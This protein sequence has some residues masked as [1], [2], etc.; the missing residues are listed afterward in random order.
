MKKLIDIKQHSDSIF[1]CHVFLMHYFE[2]K[3]FWESCFEEKVGHKIWYPIWYSIWYQI[4]YQMYNTSWKRLKK[5]HKNISKISSWLAVRQLRLSA[6]SGFQPTSITARW[7]GLRSG[8][9]QRFSRNV[10]SV[11]CQGGFMTS[12]LSPETAGSLGWRD[13]ARLELYCAFGRVHS[14]WLAV[15]YLAWP[16]V[17]SW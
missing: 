9:S 5:C 6:I 10:C 7:S 1:H 15:R 2:E 16:G 17:F 13:Q 3:V 4:G 8:D 12:Q 14:R 11:S